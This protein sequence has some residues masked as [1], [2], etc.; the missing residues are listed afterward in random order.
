VA[1]DGEQIMTDRT[2]RGYDGSP[3]LLGRT[4]GRGLALSATITEAEDAL[5]TAVQKP[6]LAD[7][8][9]DEIEDQ[10]GVLLAIRRSAR[11]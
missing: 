11:A 10:L 2:P 4:S 1:P 9:G 7:D 3:Q 6:L 8:W 5:I